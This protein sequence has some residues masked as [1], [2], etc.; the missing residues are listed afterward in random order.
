[1]IFVSRALQN[2]NYAAT[3]SAVCFRSDLTKSGNDLVFLRH[4]LSRRTFGTISRTFR[5]LAV[6]SSNRTGTGRNP[7]VCFYSPC[8]LLAPL[9]G[10][11]KL[12]SVIAY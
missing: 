8:M 3:R 11:S 4:R 10:S 6:E 7:W 9:S 5:H 2:L 1:M 12:L